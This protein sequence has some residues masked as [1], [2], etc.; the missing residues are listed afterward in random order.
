MRV[1]SV[2]FQLFPYDHEPR[3]VH[4]LYAGIEVVIDLLDDRTVALSDRVG[5][6]AP[7]NAKR[8]DVK[9][10]LQVARDHFDDLVAAWEKMHP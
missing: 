2:I 8:S 9:K 3:H 1:G 5:A 6:I 7:A 10:V 4:A